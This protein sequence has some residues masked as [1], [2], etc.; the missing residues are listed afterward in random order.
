MTNHPPAQPAHM[1]KACLVS[2][3]AHQ[4][5]FDHDWPQPL[6][7]LCTFLSPDLTGPRM[8]DVPLLRLYA[9]ESDFDLA[10]GR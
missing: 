9:Q 4:I 2:P 5:G 6:M 3:Y 10:Y 8:I 7:P 1:I